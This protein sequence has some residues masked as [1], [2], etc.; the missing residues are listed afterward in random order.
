MS[1][2]DVN[3]TD[4]G[5]TDGGATDPAATGPETAASRRG[6]ETRRFLRKL[7]RNKAV[8]VGFVVLVAFIAMALLA[9][10]ITPTDPLD[11]DLSLRLAPPSAELPFGADHQGRDMVSRVIAGSRVAMLVGFVAVGIGLVFGGLLGIVAGYFGGRLDAL[12]MR[13]MDVILAFPWLLLVIAVVSLL[14]PSLTN[15]MLAIGV[16]IVPQYARLLRSVVVSTREKDFVLAASA[17]GASHARILWAHVA[18]HTLGQTIVLSTV[19]LG[20]AIL[21]EAGLS[22]LGLGV[23]PP[24]PSWGMMIAVGQDYLRSHPHLSIVP[25]VA[26]M[27]VVVA[28]NLFGDGLADALDP[29][30]RRR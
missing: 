27:T 3:G 19:S 5:V 7:F 11:G 17:L 24:T 18:P 29:T 20:K 23:Q 6:V 25:G 2:N 30:R 9:P 16:T 22:F 10:W 28:L 15:A 12:I 4:G 26:V 1:R 14:G 8:L 13:V 21:A